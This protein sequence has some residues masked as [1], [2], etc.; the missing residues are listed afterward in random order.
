MIFKFLLFLIGFILAGAHYSSYSAFIKAVETGQA[1]RVELLLGTANPNAASY[2]NEA[3]RLASANGYS[4]I[5]RL[6]LARPEVDPGANYNEA[7]IESSRN[8]H[9][10]IVRQLLAHP[11]IDPTIHGGQAVFIASSKNYPDIVKLFI[12]DGRAIPSIFSIHTLER[13]AHFEDVDLVKFLLRYPFF[14]D[15]VL[16]VI[17]GGDLSSIKT[18]IAAGYKL[19]QKPLDMALQHARLRGDTD[20]FEF[21][22][23][24]KEKPKLPV[25]PLISMTEQCAI[26]L[27]DENLLEGYMTTCQHQFHAE[28]LQQWFSNQNSCPICRTSI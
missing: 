24:L 3:I 23:S 10:D 11:K 13:A 19:D 20:I 16:F 7:L 17:F 21:F 22:E 12:N 28:C 14:S 18:V 26:C 1:H 5:V 9:I 27:A 15:G 6:L 2:D 8:G 4:E 25:R